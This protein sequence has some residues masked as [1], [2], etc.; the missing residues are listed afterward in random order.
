M[1]WLHWLD[2][3]GLHPA[4]KQQRSARGTPFSVVRAAVGPRTAN[5]SSV[6]YHL[7]SVTATY[8]R[9]D[10]DAS[11]LLFSN[12]LIKSKEQDSDTDR[13]Q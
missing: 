12:F 5:G 8:S 7:P 4:V 2:W 1:G 10:A 9:S 3:R 13:A 11:P 6:P